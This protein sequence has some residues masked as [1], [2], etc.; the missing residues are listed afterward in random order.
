MNIFKFVFGMLIA[1]LIVVV[2][3]WTLDWSAGAIA[4][5]SIAT[6]VIA[7]LMYFGVMLAKAWFRASDKPSNAKP[8]PRKPEPDR[9]LN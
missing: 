4:A 2:Y 8:A 6:M 3:S 5:I 9:K 7:Q 1:V